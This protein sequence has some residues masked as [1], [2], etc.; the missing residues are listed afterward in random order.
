MKA[1]LAVVAGFFLTSGSG[2]LPTDVDVNANGKVLPMALM[3]DLADEF[4]L[5]PQPEGLDP[6]EANDYWLNQRVIHGKTPMDWVDYAHSFQFGSPADVSAPAHVNLASAVLR[7]YDI[8]GVPTTPADSLALSL[9]A[10]AIPIAEKSA[11]ADLVWTVA[12]VYAEQLPLAR[13]LW[14]RLPEFDIHEPILQPAERDLMASRAERIVDAVNLFFARTEGAGTEGACSGPP[15]FVDPLKLVYLGSNCDNTFPRAAG[16]FPD[17]VIVVDQGGDDTY[18]V[19]AGGAEPTGLWTNG[20]LSGNKLIVSVAADASGNDLYSWNG[21]PHVVHGGG[22]LG[23]IGL[24][25]DVQGNDRYL[26]TMTRS[27]G[28][29]FQVTYYFDGGAQG[30]GFGGYGLLLDGLGNDIYRADIRSTNGVSIWNFAQGYGAAGGIGIASDVDGVDQWLSNGIQ[31]SFTCCEFIGLYTQGSSIYAGV[32]IMTD[33][34]GDDDIYHSYDNGTT[35][36]M[37]AVAFGAFG[38]LGIVYEDGGDDSYIGV[39]KASAPWIGE[40]LNCLYGTGSYGGVGVFVDT[41]GNDRYY[42]ETISTLDAHIDNQG[43]GHP[44][45]AYGLFF[46][47]GGNDQHLEYATPGPGHT[48]TTAGRGVLSLSHNVAGNFLDRGGVDTYVG[49]GADGSVWVSGADINV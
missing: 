9:A 15:T 38:G 19:S 39:E 45:P 16:N 18:L 41:G 12:D 30:Y 31:S 22:G 4:Y 28:N 42:G 37:Y 2:Y 33:T 26:S 36:D 14:T 24:L 20:L 29:P 3:A 44:V 10:D 5:E 43:A 6:V 21:S 8:M 13:E 46:D 32:G 17:P 48:G 7:L 34:G 25:L 49:P 11:F 23:A 35:T 40:L 47:A 27:G 1:L